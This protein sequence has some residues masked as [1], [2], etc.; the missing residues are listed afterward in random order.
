MSRK[1]I[2]SDNPEWTEQDFTEARPPD[3]VL[4]A[5]VLAV[6]PRTRG[7]QQAPKK[8]AISIR[9]DSEVIEIFRNTGRG[10]QSRI[11]EV[12]KRAKV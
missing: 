4:P 3:E 7:P 6:F 10:W 12:L 1:T 5:E 8:E 9:L 11:N 2:D